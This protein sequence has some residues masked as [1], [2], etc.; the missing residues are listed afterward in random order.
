MN[1]HAEMGLITETQTY[2][3]VRILRKQAGAF[4]VLVPFLLV[5]T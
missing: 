1:I 3:T 2:S 5:P 4:R